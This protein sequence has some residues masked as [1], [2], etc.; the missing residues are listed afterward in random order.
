MIKDFIVTKI[1]GKPLIMPR[2]GD[3][4]FPDNGACWTISIENADGQAADITT[5]SGT[6]AAR[7]A[8][9]QTVTL[10]L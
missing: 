2:N 5:R 7:F 9:G 10:T 3:G 6:L 8:E 1:V 4:T